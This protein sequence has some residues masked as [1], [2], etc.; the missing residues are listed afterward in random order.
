MPVELGQSN[1]VAAAVGLWGV[2]GASCPARIG[3]ECWLFGIYCAAQKGLVCHQLLPSHDRFDGGV[4]GNQCLR[5]VNRR[6]GFD[7]NF[8]PACKACC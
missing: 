4:P 7:S 2:S 6:S 5:L 8:E 3:S 1:L